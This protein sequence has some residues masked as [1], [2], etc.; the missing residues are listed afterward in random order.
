MFLRACLFKKVGHVA[1]VAEIA[2]AFGTDDVAAPSGGDEM[3]EFVNV[4]CRTAVINESTDAVFFHFA[5]FVMVMMMVSVLFVVMLVLFVVMLVLFVVMFMFFMMM[6]M[7][8]FVVMMSVR[9]FFFLFGGRFLYPANPSC[10]G[11]HAFEVEQVC[12]YNLL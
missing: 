11:S 1:V 10:R 12:M 3:V 7:P 5:P 2:Y 8:F 9:F 4:E 6:L